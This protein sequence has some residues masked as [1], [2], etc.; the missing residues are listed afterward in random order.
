MP[1]TM[2]I[3]ITGVPFPVAAIYYMLSGFGGT[4]SHSGYWMAEFHDEHHRSFNCN[5]GVN[6]S[7]WDRLMGTEAAP[8]KGRTPIHVPAPPSLRKYVT[9]KSSFIGFVLRQLVPFD[10]KAT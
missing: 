9:S 7:F 4:M 6:G 10:D 1:A 3:C 2:G 5:F 8:V